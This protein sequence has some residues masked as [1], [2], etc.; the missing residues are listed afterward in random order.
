[1]KWTRKCI[2]IQEDDHITSV[3]FAITS[4][5]LYVA[6]VILSIHDNTKF[7]ENMWQGFKRKISCKT[8]RGEI[9][10][11]TKNNNLDYLIEI[12]D[13]NVLIEN[14]PFFDQPVKNKQEAYEKFIE[15]S[16]KDDHTTGI[17]LDYLR[18][19]IYYKLIGIDLLSQTNTGNSQQINFMENLED[20]GGVM[21]FIPEKQQKN[22]P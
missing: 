3:S 22:Y 11:Q 10:V 21:C 1:M 8:C 19:Q 15:I 13:F 9:I 4:T 16:E 6:I 5:K 18:H 12:K 20:A 17:L 2:L 14:E 7:L